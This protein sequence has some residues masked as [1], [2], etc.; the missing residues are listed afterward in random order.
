MK[1]RVFSI[2]LAC[3][4][5]FGALSVHALAARTWEI[6]SGSTSRKL[7]DIIA[8]I[9][10][11]D[12]GPAATPPSISDNPSDPAVILPFTDVR[13]DSW[14]VDDL[15]YIYS[16]GLMSGITDTEFGPDAPTS[17]G[18]LVT[19]LYRLEG[20]PAVDQGSIFSDV[21]ADSYYANAVT[22]AVSNGIVNGLEGGGTFAP[23]NDITRQELASILYRYAVSK[24]YTV[25]GRGSLS[26]YEDA[27]Q[28]SEYAVEALVWANRMG[29]INGVTQNTLEPKGLAKRC[30]VAAILHRFC[31]S[32]AR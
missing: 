6:G 8:A 20:Q 14:Y 9:P 23:K 4:L 28:A 21:P 26:A 2:L 32:V 13:D 18:M 15:K 19:M 16:Q 25:S 22:W 12:P 29:L 1:K 30:E 27:D 11:E 5:L 17:R 24:G 3:V 7:A 31:V 10:P